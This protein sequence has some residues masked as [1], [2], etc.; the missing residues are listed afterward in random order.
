MKWSEYE[1]KKILELRA[2]GYS[3]NQLVRE[4][5]EDP[6][7]HPRSFEAIRAFFRHY[8]LKNQE[9]PKTSDIMNILKYLI[10]LWNFLF[11]FTLNHFF[12]TIS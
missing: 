7:C 8:K 5:E 10:Y 6:Q 4:F 12:K 3:Y 2:K 1:K 9:I 11:R